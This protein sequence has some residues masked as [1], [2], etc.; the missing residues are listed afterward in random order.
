MDKQAVREKL[1]GQKLTEY[2]SANPSKKTVVMRA[3]IG[4]GNVYWRATKEGTNVF[5][6]TEVTTKEES[7]SVVTESKKKALSEAKPSKASSTKNGAQKTISAKSKATSSTAKPDKKDKAAS[8]KPDVSKTDKA[9]NYDR[10]M[11]STS[12]G[13]PIKNAM[14]PAYKDMHF[15]QP[16]ST[17]RDSALKSNFSAYSK[18]DHADA[19]SAHERSSMLAHLAGDDL[20]SK[21]H[22]NASIAHDLASGGAAPG[23]VKKSK[24]V[25]NTARDAG[26]DLQA[27]QWGDPAM[28]A[29]GPANEG[30]IGNPLDHDERLRLLKKKK[31]KKEGKI[32]NPLD[33]SE[34]WRRKLIAQKL[35]KEDA[36]ALVS[37]IGAKPKKAK[38]A[39]KNLEVV[40]QA[41][42]P[43]PEDSPTDWPYDE[44]TKGCI[45]N[46]PYASGQRMTS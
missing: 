41:L 8:V 22:A 32:G 9:A 4:E 7:F 44:I 25:E 12:S 6:V 19:S 36:K 24:D 33:D 37:E 34:R 42:Y 5:K 18:Q 46:A 3:N 43:E 31:L 28:M 35:V 40:A 27:T 14:H 11:G 15:S 16:G 10:F 20:G 17:A 13:K 38:K 29:A 26:W 45:S 1:L 39:L 30:K 2:F 23:K 21:L